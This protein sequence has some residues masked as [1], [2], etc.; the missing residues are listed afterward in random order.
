MKNWLIWSIEHGMWW[1]E[2]DNGY[3]QQ[4]NKAG[5]Y[6]FERAMKIVSGA[7]I[8]LHDI[9]NEAMIKITL[10]ELK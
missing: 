6:T 5:R 4:R 2:N 7:N 3:V 9:P 1:G 8:G 10:D